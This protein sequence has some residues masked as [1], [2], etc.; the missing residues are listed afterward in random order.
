MIMVFL[1][2]SLILSIEMYFAAEWYIK[3]VSVSVWTMNRQKT[4]FLCKWS[5]NE[6]KLEF[7]MI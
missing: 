6:E 7:D 3:T 4:V 1:M 5:V 2:Q